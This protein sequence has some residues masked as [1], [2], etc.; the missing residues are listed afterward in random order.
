VLRDEVLDY[1]DKADVLK[2][3]V[4]ETY[5]AAVISATSLKDYFWQE[6]KKVESNRFYRLDED[7]LNKRVKRSLYRTGASVILATCFYSCSPGIIR[8]MENEEVFSCYEKA[9]EEM[10]VQ[11]LITI[12]S[13][14]G[15]IDIKNLEEKL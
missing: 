15:I 10:G 1:K 4:A 11:P 3:I 8:E 7:K 9:C 5:K 6:I 13:G 14:K 2:E 12:N